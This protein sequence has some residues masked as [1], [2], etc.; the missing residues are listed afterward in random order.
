MSDIRT[1]SIA[2]KHVKKIENRYTQWIEEKICRKTERKKSKKKR[3][4]G[5]VWERG[6]SYTALLALLLLVLVKSAADSD[7][8][9]ALRLCDWSLPTTFTMM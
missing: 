2:D 3:E 1:T 6:Q 4:E 9:G 5:G 7:E 8:S